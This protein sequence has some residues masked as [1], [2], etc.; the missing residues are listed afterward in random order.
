M[1]EMPSQEPSFTAI[2]A[3]KETPPVRTVNVAKLKDQLSKYLTFAKRGEEVVIRDRNLPVAKLV[4]FS[5]KTA[6]EQELTLV[7]AGKL[8]LPVEQLDI[9]ALLKIPTATVKGNKAVQALLTDRE[10]GM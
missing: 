9:K 3:M 5:P 4:P 7:A 6:D 1:I 10:E 2:I 8:R